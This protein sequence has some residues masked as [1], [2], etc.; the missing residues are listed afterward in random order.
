[1]RR[2]RRRSFRGDC[3]VD[4]DEVPASSR[5]NHMVAAADVAMMEM[6]EA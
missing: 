3:A 5:S 4:V 1:V 6:G 2:F